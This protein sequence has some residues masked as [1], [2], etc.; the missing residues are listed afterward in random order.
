MPYHPALR[1]IVLSA[2]GL[3]LVGCNTTSGHTPRQ[4][5]VLLTFTT[6]VQGAAPGGKDAMPF[7]RLA[8]TDAEMTAIAV[9]LSSLDRPKLNAVNPA[10][11]VII[12]AFQGLQP[13][14]GYRIEILTVKVT[15]E[16][17]DVIVR[18]SSPA[19]GEPVR[20]GFE[21]PYHLVQVAHNEFSK[22]KLAHYRLTDSSGD[23]LLEGTM[24][25]L[26]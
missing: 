17:L 1:H 23:V 3:I 20:Q 7:L 22:Y 18:R 4:S 16:T 19:T 25:S 6:I 5:D 21:S 9:R 2:V 14:S 11:S 26:N 13:T 24:E 8:K 10:N 12:A 15:G